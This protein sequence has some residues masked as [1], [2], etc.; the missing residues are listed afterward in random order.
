MQ[1]TKRSQ[2]YSQRLKDIGEV[3]SLNLLNYE[4]EKLNKELAYKILN[5][6]LAY[7][8]L[9]KEIFMKDSTCTVP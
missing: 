2:N 6:K 5:E 3:D 4:I 9:K 8:K 7:L 1:V